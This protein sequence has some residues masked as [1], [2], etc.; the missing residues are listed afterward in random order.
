MMDKVQKKAK[1]LSQAGGLR[2]LLV[3]MVAGGQLYHTR[4]KTHS[5]PVVRVS[6]PLAIWAAIVGLSHRLA[7]VLNHLEDIDCH[8]MGLQERCQRVL[9]DPNIIINM[10]AHTILNVSYINFATNMCNV[11]EVVQTTVMVISILVTS[12]LFRAIFRLLAWNLQLAL[13]EARLPSHVMGGS[14]GL[15]V[16]RLQV[17]CLRVEEAK[18]ALLDYLGLPIGGLLLG[19]AITMV[20]TFFFVIKVN[21]DHT[22]ITVLNVSV[23][24]S[25]IMI[26]SAPQQLRDQVCL[27]LATLRRVSD[28]SVIGAFSLGNHNILQERRK[29]TFYL[30]LEREE[31]RTESVKRK[32]QEKI[33]T[34]TS[35]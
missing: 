1:V 16:H 27:T 19:Y 7:R 11:V 29:S 32:R 10:I 14:R 34:T 20:V 4:D 35:E 9:R 2:P 15:D 28:M 26:C 3:A 6:P 17:V 24:I 18:A 22:F 21:D 13:A 8:L 12:S 33:R 25:L 23:I 30:V 31:R 5:P